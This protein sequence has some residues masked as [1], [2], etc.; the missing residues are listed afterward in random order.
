M[1]P[2]SPGRRFVCL[3]VLMWTAFATNAQTLVGG[4]LYESTRPE[5]TLEQSLWLQYSNTFEFK[6]GMSIESD[7][8]QIFYAG[9]RKRF[10]VRSNFRY[11]ITNNLSAG[12]G[13]GFFWFY[14]IRDLTQ[15]LR[16]AQSLRYR[17]DFGIPIMQH[18]LQLEQQI[19]QAVESGEH[20]DHRLRYRFGLE[21]PSDGH[22]YFGLYDEVFFNLN[23]SATDRTVQQNRAGAYLGYNT[24]NFFRLEAHAMRVHEFHSNRATLSSWIFQLT[25]RHSI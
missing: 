15:E 24:F 4:S 3:C 11:Q 17:K 8:G 14:G 20:V 7:F 12:A 13:M 9:G 5:S 25:A 23:A 18:D 6:P 1:N 16:F 2:L 10:N 19:F 22:M 21:I